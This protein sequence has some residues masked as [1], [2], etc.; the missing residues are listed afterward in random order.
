MAL[1]DGKTIAARLPQVA[2]EMEFKRSSLSV[3]DEKN[4]PGTPLPYG[5]RPPRI[6]VMQPDLT[7]I[8]QDGKTFRARYIGVDGQTGL[9]VLQLT[10][11]ATTADIPA[12]TYEN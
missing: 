7:V 6:T 3:P 4:F 2:A 9:S 11:P 10:Q 12:R 1:E 8:M 5:I